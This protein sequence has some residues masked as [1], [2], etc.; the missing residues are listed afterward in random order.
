MIDS[1]KIICCIRVPKY[2]IVGILHLRVGS[3]LALLF[4]G[5]FSE[6]ENPIQFLLL[7]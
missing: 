4:L 6:A 1:G 7:R 2:R 3:R 5:T